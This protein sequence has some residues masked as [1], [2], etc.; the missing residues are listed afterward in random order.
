MLGW[1][2]TR[3][4]YKT[5]CPEKNSNYQVFTC[6][7][8]FVFTSTGWFA[9]ICVFLLG[10]SRRGSGLRGTGAKGP[11]RDTGNE[12]QWDSRRAMG[13]VTYTS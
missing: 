5:L 11:G 12:G 2:V 7:A 13:P 10:R 9:Q 8:P 3:S 4:I 1:R 6:S